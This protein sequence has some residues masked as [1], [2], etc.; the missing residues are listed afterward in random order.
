MDKPENSTLLNVCIIP[1]DRVSAAF[2]ALSQ[3]LQSEH[4]LFTLGEGLFA[5]M[6]VYMARFADEDV[7]TVVNSVGAALASARPFRCEHTGYFMTEGRYLEASY[8]KSPACMQFHEQMITHN[9]DLR[10][11]PGHPFNEGYFAPYTDEQRQNAQETGYDLARNL[12]RP[13]VTLTRYTEGNVPAV[14]P[15]LPAA[16]L[17]FDVGK[18][19]VYKA[20][21]NGA[22]YELIREF[23][24]AT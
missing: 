5:H 10:I 12:Y 21:D 15:A 23:S 13:H 22:I 8:R 1:D 19:C 20:D 6:T 24:L 4:T 3:S 18:I 2:A 9:K 11:N 16:K 7:P 17:S 14:F